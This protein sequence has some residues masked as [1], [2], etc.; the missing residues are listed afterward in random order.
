ML[1][2]SDLLTRG[3]FHD[4]V[5][6]P[7]GSSY[8]LP[9]VAD[10]EAYVRHRRKRI[11]SRCVQHSV[12]K[13]RHLRRLLSI[14]NP[15]HQ[16]ALSREI[17]RH[18]DEL[19]TFCGQSTVSLSVPELSTKRALQ[20]K[21]EIA[22]VTTEKALRSVGARYLLKTDLARYYP[23]IY[24]HSIAWAL[25]GKDNERAD[26]SLYGNT[27]DERVRNTQDQQTGGIPIG[28]DTSFLIGEVIGSA[29]DV[30]LAE[31]IGDLHG[32]RF[33]DDFYLYFESLPEAE[34]ALAQLH[35]IA[36]S[37]ELEI[38]DQKTE[39]SSL[40]DEIEPAWKTELRAMQIRD[41]GQPQ[42]TDLVSLF[43]KGFE[44]AKRFQSDNVLTYVAK[45]VANASIDADNWQLAQALL[46][47][48]AV[49]EPTMLSVLIEILDANA[50]VISDTE[51][52]RAAV[53]SL[54][55][56]HAPL[57]QGYEVAW[58][59]WLARRLG[60]S[61]PD[62]VCDLVADMD[63]DIVAL[64]ALDLRQNGQFSILTNVSRWESLMTSQNLYSEHWLLAY[65]AY[66]HQWLPSGDGSDYIG[67][68]EMFSI[69]RNRAVLF[70][71][72]TLTGVPVS[73]T[74]Y[75]EEDEVDQSENEMEEL[76]LEEIPFELLSG[77][78]PSEGG[79]GSE[80]GK[81]QSDT[82]GKPGRDET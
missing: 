43:N 41:A 44:L 50:P 48:A 79:R 12:P 56:Y 19:H 15:F 57:Q 39:I 52:L 75:E 64:V 67:T 31:A 30:C 73:A 32:V 7:L 28:P 81:V 68:D 66:E 71:D 23:S 76:P 51:P 37:F 11:R 70:Y 49:A 6:P 2:V 4:R 35:K 45:Q 74:G 20:T 69:L 38:H 58:A 60:I 34:R 33:I 53:S 42:S 22:A 47:K 9:A 17:A 25:H 77:A 14:P 27:L 10:L 18:W 59:L 46:L 54:C 3:Y 62:Q 8:L 29:I 80:Q 82:S 1:T 26:K 72:P 55:S 5:I 78:T 40:P 24:T 16:T 21:R 13:K 36:K 63:D 65:E 61:I